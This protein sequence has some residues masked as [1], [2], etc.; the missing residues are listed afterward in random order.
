MN[1]VAK[2][3]NCHPNTVRQHLAD[4]GFFKMAGSK[5][6]RVKRSDLDRVKKNKRIMTVGYLCRSRRKENVDLQTK[7]KRSV[8]G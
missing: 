4:W 2:E 5:V 8:V 7:S 3:L 1:Q 6:W